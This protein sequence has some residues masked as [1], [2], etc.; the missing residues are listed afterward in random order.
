MRWC[1]V[2]AWMKAGVGMSRRKPRHSNA[3]SLIFSFL[4]AQPSSERV[5]RRRM[6]T[7]RALPR[8][9]AF[10]YVCTP[11]VR[12]W[13]CPWEAF[14][15]TASRFVVRRSHT[16]ATASR[17]LDWGADWM[18]SR[19]LFRAQVR[20]DCFDDLDLDRMTS[21]QPYA[22]GI[23]APNIAIARCPSRECGRR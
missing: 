15:A 6:E 14:G 9:Y 11:W 5:M 10:R 21:E 17:Q 13:S 2:D 3:G 22:D 20:I 12:V 1:M 8:V 18:S 19:V 7:H 16:K 23:H 4:Y